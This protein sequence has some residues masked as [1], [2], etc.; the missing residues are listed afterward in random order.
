MCIFKGKIKLSLLLSGAHV[1][2][3][4]DSAQEKND[5]EEGDEILKDAKLISVHQL[6]MSITAKLLTL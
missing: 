6:G 1:E 3:L 5:E 2:F 4:D